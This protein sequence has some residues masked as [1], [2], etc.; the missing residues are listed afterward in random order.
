MKFQ[1]KSSLNV[2]KQIYK[3]CNGYVRIALTSLIT[4][5]G[6]IIMILSDYHVHSTFSGD[7]QSTMK[8]VIETAIA[9]GMQ[10]L[11]FTEHHDIDIDSPGYNFLLDFE[12]Y[13]ED[14]L[15]Y[16]EQYSSKISLHMGIEM[17]IQPHLYE[18]LTRIAGAYPF[19]FILCSNHVVDGIDPYFPQFFLDKTKPEAYH[20]YFNEILINA[21][22]FEAYDVF[23]HLDYVIRYGPYDEKKYLYEEFQEVLDSVLKILI[24][25]GKGIELNASGFKY[26]LADSH[27]SY[28]VIERY[29]ALG[30]EIITIG[31]DAHRSEQLMNH[32]DLAEGILK[33]AGFAYYTV[34]KNRKPAFIKL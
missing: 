2:L 19:D 34:F 12:S 3:L 18:E 9:K 23:G 1:V 30:G 11:C 22:K 7:G 15:K 27:P 6:E 17:G 28:Q 16:K 33:N 24:H 25:K 8:D 5:K 31:S 13:M 21:Q 26:G 10:N 20:G 14:F 29:R 4:T 32:F